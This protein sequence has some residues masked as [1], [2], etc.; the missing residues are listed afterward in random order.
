MNRAFNASRAIWAGLI[1]GIVF[2]MAE[3]ILVG[4]VGGGSP[5]GPPRM[6]AAMAMGKDVLPPPATFDITI[7]VVAM[8]IH[9]VLSIIL[10]IIFAW[11]ADRLAWSRTT[12]IVAGMV[13]GLIIYVVNFYG[14]TA[15]FPWFAMARGWI[16]ILAHLMFGGVL[17][18][19]YA[20]G[21]AHRVADDR[22]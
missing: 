1:A 18:W 20:A 4:T 2:M 10:G 22:V 9:L 16:S 21:Y 14:M 11:V 8:M 19:Y 7:F 6:I 12:T 5:W 13:F 15:M 3:M 17:G